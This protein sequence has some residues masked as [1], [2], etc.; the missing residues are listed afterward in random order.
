MS[1]ARKFELLH[2]PGRSHAF[3]IIMLRWKSFSRVF[4]LLALLISLLAG[5]SAPMFLD[6][7]VKAAPMSVVIPGNV[8]ISEFRTS[9]VLG[10]SD[11]FIELYNKTTSPIDIGSWIYKRSGTCLTGNGNPLSITNM[12]S[13]PV[14]T[15]LDPGQHF[16]IG[17]TSYSDPV[18][19]DISTTLAIADD[20]GIAIYFS[21]NITIS[22]SVGLCITSPFVEVTN[23]DPIIQEIPPTNQGYERNFG[24]LLDSCVDTDINV[25]DFLPIP[26]SE[27]QNQFSDSPNFSLCGNAPPTATGTPI[28]TATGIATVTRTPAGPGPTAIPLL[29][30]LINEVAWA[31]TSASTEDEWIELYNP[32]SVD[33]DLKDYILETDSDSVIISWDV[34]DADHV[35]EKNTY[36]LIEK[37]TDDYPVSDIPY[38][39]AFSGNLSNN[40]EILR[41]TNNSTGQL[42]DI[43]NSDGGA[44]PAGS[45]TTFRSMERYSTEGT[46]QDGT[47]AW[48]TNTGVVKNGLDAGKPNG[49]TTS[50]TTLPQA[51]NGT[52]R[53]ANWA[54]IVKVTPSRTPPPT[55]PTKKPTPFRS[56][57]PV[58]VI[59]G[60]PI[61]NEFLARPGFDWNQDGKINVFDEFIEIK[62]AGAVAI[63]LSGFRLD[64]EAG[65]GSEPFTLSNIILQPG[66]RIVYY[67]LETNILLSDGGDTV[68]L[69]HPNGEVYDSYTY[70]VA[71]NEDQ[72]ICRMPDSKS[73]EFG[74]GEWKTDCIPTPN[75]ANTREGKV[76]S[77][78][79][80]T[81]EPA[82]CDLPDTLPADFLFA[83]CR[84]YGANIWSTFYWDQPGWQ[85]E[86]YIPENMSKWESFIK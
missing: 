39:K 45:S 31:G 12:G 62:N 13:I 18:E 56:P 84:G 52:P 24:G 46:R 53:Q 8:V 76:P 43:A 22:D 71:K 16:L 20:G 30:L 68:R 74:F 58:V 34:T 32:G 28:P 63:S 83:E 40:G 11:E 73:N 80:E 23:L 49:C 27:P 50:C 75:I 5:I 65:L 57:T 81:F 29:T 26:V 14:D 77:A 70:P 55:V 9:G 67:G 44:W 47:A 86:L 1:F 3:F 7:F 17:G 69:L 72:S 4:L 2:A 61:I 33:I 19:P 54:S 36:Y 38:D 66:E 59:V 85:G 42:V 82:V 79:G 41:L 6:D 21:D 10:P 25:D 15:I 78:P 51:I 37:G 48:V 35:I 64:D 60:R